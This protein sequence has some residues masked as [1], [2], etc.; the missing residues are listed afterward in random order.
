L[1]AL[2]G[3]G[4]VALLIN[5]GV[6]TEF[7]RYLAHNWVA[8]Q[9]DLISRLQAFYQRR[10]NW[11]GV[12]E[13]LEGA[14]RGYKGRGRGPGHRG[15]ILML[16]DAQGVVV[17]NRRGEHTGAELSQQQ[18][19]QA[20]PIQID[21]D[22][23]G[24]LAVEPIGR[25]GLGPRE[26][27]FLNQL[28][29]ILLLAGLLAGGL[30]IL[31]GVVF[32][33]RLSAPLARLAAAARALATG[34][35]NTRVRVNGSDEIRAAAEAF[36]S[37]AEELQ[38]AETLRR[39]LVADVAHELRTPLTVLQGNLRAL[40]DGVYPLEQAEIAN[41]Y[42]E[43]R[44]LSRLVEDLHQLAQ[45]EAGQLRLDMH[46]VDLIELVQQTVDSFAIAVEAK[47]ITLDVDLPPGLPLVKADP[48]RTA[49]V[50]RNLLSN[51][52]Q[53]TPPGG[54]I[55]IQVSA[56]VSSPYLR[57]TVTDTGPGISPEDLPHVFDRFWRG[58]KSRARDRGGAG[59][60][61]AIAKSLVEAM[62]GQIGAESEP[63]CGSRFWFTL[64]TADF[65]AK[66]P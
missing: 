48:D 8:G 17:Y 27:T 9:E 31:L 35:L 60:G 40:L 34:D 58:E 57:V 63:G 53:H 49:Q 38:R 47:S 3:I 23:I 16:A 14:L 41:L 26:E 55:G 39:N 51:A 66:I 42:D 6:G 43:T 59:L 54:A 33:Q 24:Y 12:E 65:C 4:S 19:S 64:T 13:V 21:G 36:N 50:L 45:A 7:R 18:R 22:T 32:S 1:V 62:G 30:S 5:Y 28:N 11:Q 46:P 56:S 15:I 2:I 10:G 44:L 52:L 37:M 29:R 20:L 61:L 25:V